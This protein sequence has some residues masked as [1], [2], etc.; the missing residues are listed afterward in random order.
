MTISS[1]RPGRAQFGRTRFGRAVFAPLFLALCLAST[2][3]AADEANP[4]KAEAELKAVRSQIEKMQAELERDAGRRD[5][6][7]R[8]LE[9][10]EKTVSG[11]RGELDKLRRERAVHT[12]RRAELAEA[13]RKEEAE[14][15]ERRAALAG[16]IR[17]AHMIGQEEPLKLL[18]N[19]RDPAQTGRVLTYYQYFGRARAGQIAA[20]NS[21]I[22]ELATL[23]AG[24]AEEEAR[25]AALEEAQKGELSRL[26]GARERRGRVLVSL[27]TESKNRARELAR[28]KDQQGGLEKLVRELRRALERIDKF[29][30]DSKDAFAKL[31]GK[32]AWPVAG[33]LLASFGQNRAGG[34][35]WDGVLVSGSQGAAVRAVYHGR[36]VYA[37]WLS[38]LGLLT[39]I[40]HGDGYLS[41]YGHNERL[42]K[43]VGERVTAGDTIATVGDSGGRSTPALYFEIRKAGR[44]VDPRPWFK[45]ASP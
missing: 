29:P 44:P 17:A 14:L 28:L 2:A 34:V 15:A 12:A 40:D 42:Y 36:V 37:D 7:T 9:E 27:E 11:A 43:E 1:S 32:L 24:L 23:D 35:K 21:H 25:L 26:Q 31:R 18:L 19:Q 6:I 38:G 4:A 22:A 5:K 3:P 33:K 8:E 10:S 30:S 39:I 41:L 13:R 16:Q 20:I 45:S